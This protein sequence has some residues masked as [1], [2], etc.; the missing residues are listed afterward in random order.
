[1][2]NKARR[3]ES[4]VVMGWTARRP[5]REGVERELAGVPHQ[6][7]GPVHVHHWP[8]KGMGGGWRRDDRVIPLCLGHHAAA[9]R[10][11]IPRER[12]ERYARDNL[13]DFLDL[14]SSEEVVI[15]MRD[16][17]RFRVTPGWIPL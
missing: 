3:V 13:L 14:A 10:Y 11:E 9:H 4:T 2:L 12:Q 8:P 16:L 1:M 15:Y 17:D 5:C 7:E 6:C